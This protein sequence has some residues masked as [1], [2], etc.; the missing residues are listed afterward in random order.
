MPSLLSL[1]VFVQM[2]AS[3][4]CSARVAFTSNYMPVRH[5]FAQK[6]TQYRSRVFAAAVDDEQMVDMADLI[7]SAPTK[8]DMMR[9][10]YMGLESPST[11]EGSEFSYAEFDDSINAHMPTFN[12]GDKVTGTVVTFD[13]EG[14]MIDIGAKACAFLPKNEASIT[15][16]VRPEDVIG[17]DESVEVEIISGEDEN[18]Q[19]SVSVRRIQLA[20]AWEKVSEMET[21]DESFEAEVISVNRGGALVSVEGLRAFL[22]GSHLVG[23]IPGD[24]LVG[25][26]LMFK[27]LQVDKDANKLVVSNRRAMVDRQI[28]EMKPGKVVIGIVRGVKPYGAF[29]DVGGMQGLLHISQISHDHIDNVEAILPMG[30]SIKAMVINQ[31]KEKGRIALS[32][33]TL[34]PEPGDMLRDSAMVFDKAEET[35]E[36]YQEKMEAERKAREEAALDV[37]MGLETALSGLDST[38]GSGE[39]TTV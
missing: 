25:E 8:F 9:L 35:A 21:S 11:E 36:K 18:G 10:K 31:D 33:K 19:L 6:A 27:F 26:R 28:N 17:M 3:H 37:I 13:P 24:D 15:L 20:K 30:A 34:E 23:R 7:G 12:R 4:A 32:T 29:I 14:A 39:P 22:P 38:E 2:V 1:A 5:N 16:G